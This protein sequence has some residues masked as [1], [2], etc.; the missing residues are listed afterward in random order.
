MKAGSGN[1][2]SQAGG[3]RG[4]RMRVELVE[5]FRGMSCVLAIGRCPGF[6]AFW[7]DLS[8]GHYIPGTDRF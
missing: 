8:A 4:E 2:D 5:T 3:A 1:L 6:L 7:Q